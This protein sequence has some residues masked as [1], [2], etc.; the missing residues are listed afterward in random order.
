MIDIKTFLKPG[1]GD[2]FRA[3]LSLDPLYKAHDELAFGNPA[4]SQARTGAKFLLV[5]LSFP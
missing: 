2:P 1:P 4:W 3:S 5:R